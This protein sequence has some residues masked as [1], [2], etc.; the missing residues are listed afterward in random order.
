MLLYVLDLTTSH[1]CYPKEDAI[2]FHLDPI[3]SCGAYPRS[4]GLRFDVNVG[5]VYG[6]RVSNLEVNPKLA[7]SWTPIGTNASYIVITSS[8]LANGR[9]GFYEFANISDELK[10]DT[11][12]E[13][14]QSFV[15][16]AKSVGILEPVPADRASTQIWKTAVAE[17]RPAEKPEV[18][19]TTATNVPV[20]EPITETESKGNI[21]SLSLFALAVAVLALSSYFQY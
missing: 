7:G 6:S 14:A 15:D 8:F 1:F 21:I 9:D 5:E 17:E 2:A 11:Y 12:L 4:S 19:S 13:Y 3:G 10:V 18:A 20:G 16:Y